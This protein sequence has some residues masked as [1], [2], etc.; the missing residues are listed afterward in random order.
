M[1]TKAMITTLV[2]TIGLGISAISMPANAASWHKG[3]PA[4]LRGVYQYKKYSQA[5]GFGDIVRMYPNRIEISQSNNPLW[6]ITNIHYKKMGRYYHIIGHRHHEGFIRSGKDNLMMY[7]KGHYFKYTDY[8]YFVGHGF[9][10][11]HAG[12]RVNH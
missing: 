3:T 8:S 5:Q 6:K 11:L 7:R 12:K 9:K 10:G 2:L 4:V 1:K